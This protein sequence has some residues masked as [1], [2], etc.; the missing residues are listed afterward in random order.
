VALCATVLVYAALGALG[1]GCGQF[2]VSGDES[3]AAPAG[4]ADALPMFDGTP[5]PDAAATADADAGATAP[6]AACGMHDFCA[7]F[8][9]SPPDNGWTTNHASQGSL[10]IVQGAGW[11][12]NAL[13]SSL[14]MQSA[15]N[16]AYVVKEFPGAKGIHVELE[17]RVPNTTL[18][19]AAVL[20]LVQFGGSGTDEAGVGVVLS[21]APTKL[22]LYVAFGNGN[23]TTL[24]AAS[25]L[26]REQWVHLVFEM[27]FGSN[28]TLSLAV[29]GTSVFNQGLTT[30]SP[31]TTPELRIG[32]QHYNGPTPAVDVLFDTIRAD[33][34]K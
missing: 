34:L 31:T 33:L 3:D 9:Q 11:P 2:G 1:G 5:A 21:S 18:D 20:T 32:M 10:A 15:S 29:D 17:V 30:T 14:M 25:D 7:D 6:D 13:S 4:V 8:E 19:A 26:R 22:G 28:T 23:S 16:W 27:H 24:T 12:G